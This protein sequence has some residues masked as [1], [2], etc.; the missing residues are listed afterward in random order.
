MDA[1]FSLRNVSK[2]YG[3]LSV[4]AGLS[5][6]VPKDRIVALLGPSGCGKTTLLSV[7]AGVVPTD[8]GQVLGLAGKEMSYLFQEPR[9][10]DWMTVAQNVAF[11]LKDKLD[12]E[13]IGPEVEMWL[14]RVG[15]KGYEK[16]YPRRL[17]GGQRQRVAMARAL[18]YPSRILLMDEPFKSLD[19]GLKLDL[20]RDFLALWTDAPRTVLYVTHDV[21]EAVLLADIVHVLSDKPTVVRS[22]HEINIPRL[23]RPMDNIDVLKLEHELTLTLLAGR[24]S[25][26]GQPPPQP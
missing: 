25:P 1:E 20:I 9:L 14:D 23:E 24:S 15:L 18:A 11:V 4:L 21:R 7:I 2:S 12:R 3:D 26:V 6:D 10:L 16:I 17:S 5:L 19:L 8:S 13:A 22:T